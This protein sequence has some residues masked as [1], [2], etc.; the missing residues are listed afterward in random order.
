MSYETIARFAQ[1]AGS[2]YFLILFACG[3]AYAFWPSN[4]TKFSN[5]KQAVLGEEDGA[6]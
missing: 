2:V 3:F 1:Q 4:R 5:A 6:Q